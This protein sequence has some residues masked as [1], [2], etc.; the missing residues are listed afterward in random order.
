MNDYKL[1]QTDERLEIINTYGEY[2][3]KW[4]FHPEEPFNDCEFYIMCY[5][6][7]PIIR[8]NIDDIDKFTAQLL[9]YAINDINSKE[10]KK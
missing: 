7:E 1:G 8:G 9:T 3:R 6:N 5:G 10:D 2:N 4:W